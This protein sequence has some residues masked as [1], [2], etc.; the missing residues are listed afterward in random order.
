MSPLFSTFIPSS[1]CIL[2][3]WAEL[4][5]IPLRILSA[6]CRCINAP[7]MHLWRN[8]CTVIQ[9]RPRSNNYLSLCV[10]AQAKLLLLLTLDVNVT[11]GCMQVGYPCED[12][13]SKSSGF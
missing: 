4:D 1:R 12:Y 11:A 8:P 10:Q 2:H 13:C 6:I 9:N 7:F 3:V 5:V